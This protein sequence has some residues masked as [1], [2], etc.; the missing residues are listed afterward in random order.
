MCVSFSL[1]TIQRATNGLISR[2]HPGVFTPSILF[3][4]ALWQDIWNPSCSNLIMFWPQGMHLTYSPTNL[5]N[6]WLSSPY[7]SITFQTW[8]GLSHPSI[9]DIL[10]CMCT[11]PI[12]VSCV[13]LLHCTHGNEHIG[14]H[15]A[16][17]DTF[18]AIAQDVDFHVGRK[19]LHA[20]P[21]TTLHSSR[22]WVDIV[23]T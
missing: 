11:H 14:T 13:L 10:Q 22:R 4:H 2:F 9:I 23:F 15:D 3:Q 1:W 5:P 20:L 21:S 16:V 19:Q 18:V 6:L 8:L 17:H 12:D 7:F